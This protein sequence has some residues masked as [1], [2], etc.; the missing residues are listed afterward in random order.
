MT[1]KNKFRKSFVT[2]ISFLFFKAALF[3]ENRFC[4]KYS[5]KPCRRSSAAELIGQ[6]EILLSLLNTL[7]INL[8]NFPFFSFFL[9]HQ[10]PLSYILADLAIDI[11]ID[12]V[13]KYFP[14]NNRLNTLEMVI[15]G[16]N[17]ECTPYCS[18]ESTRCAILFTSIG[19]SV[20]SLK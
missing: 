19:S 5:E 3:L 12:F 15:F 2:K 10:Y 17:S 1:A 6:L 13:L 8:F 4:N 16:A 14:K 11:L 9:Y 20:N 18:T 7:F